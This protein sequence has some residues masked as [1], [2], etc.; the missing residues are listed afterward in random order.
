MPFTTAQLQAELQADTAALGYASRVAA[1]NDAGVVALINTPG[2]TDVFRNDIGVREVIDAIVP[3]DFAALT[4]LQIAKL[5]MMFIGTDHIDATSANTRTIFT[6]IFGN[7]SNTV[8]AL[9]ALAK[10]KGSR[11]EVLWGTG[12]AVTLADVSLAL[13]GTR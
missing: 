4:A 7:A 13:R 6:G 2:S 9:T 12:T 5:Q 10:R 11:A 3:A 8:T 1:G